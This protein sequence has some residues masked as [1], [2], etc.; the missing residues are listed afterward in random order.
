[1][2]PRFPATSGSWSD[3]SATVRDQV[4]IWDLSAGTFTELAVDLPGDL[5]GCFTAEGDGVVL[6]HTHQARTTV[7]RYDPA[8]GVL[9]PV[10]VSRGVVSGVV[11]RPDGSL[12]YR[13]SSAE[14]GA[15][16]RT[17]RPDGADGP[18]LL[19]PDGGPA[20]SVPVEDLW[21]LGQG[22]SIHALV[23]RPAGR[24][25][26]AL[27]TV[28]LVHGGPNAAD[29]D[30]FDAERATFVDAGFAVCQVNYRGSTG[31][32]SAWRDALSRRVGHT[33][34]ADIA[35]RPTTTWSAPGRLTRRPAR[36]SGRPGAAT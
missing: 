8:T 33:E 30:A 11:T 26:G 24:P 28:F 13:H 31:Y 25:E 4:G 15:R 32:G 10:P 16:L 2:S 21:V 19:P 20:D 9:G 23:A 29:E 18:L 14:H 22:G 34:L 12:W 36:S 27:P 5:D 6:L 17:L 3:T 35:R 1:M 7:H